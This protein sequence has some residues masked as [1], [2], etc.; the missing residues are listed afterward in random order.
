MS[1]KPAVMLVIT[2]TLAALAAAAV[3]AL[4]APA[5]AQARAQAPSVTTGAATQVSY[6]SAVLSGVVNPRGADTT[7]YVQYGPTKAYGL[8]TAVAT[9]GAGDAAVPVSVAVAGL[10]P[11]TSYHYRL[12]ALNSAGAGV[13]GDRS[14][15]TAPIPLSLQILGAPNPTS[16]AAPTVIEGTLSG[17]GNANRAVVLQ[18]NPFPYVQGFADVGN[19]ELTSATGSFAFP[20]LGLTDASQF[21]VVTITKTPI[22]SPILIE[23]VAVSVTIETQRSQRRHH[24]RIF[25]AVTPNVEGMP[26]EIFKVVNGHP[27]LVATTFTRGLSASSAHYDAVIRRP[28][29]GGVYEAL[30]R[31]T[32]GAQT[33][34]DSPPAFVHGRQR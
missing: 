31:V 16:Y 11:A 8:Q 4:V 7:Y 5:A 12:V 30:V 28:R 14:F 1:R 24:V 29:R 19:P 18:E 21:R 17:T 23:G 32:N 2:S 10:A 9:A 25:G 3:P 27:I 15:K 34:A 22:V 33:S 6:G 26:V 20:I 13:G